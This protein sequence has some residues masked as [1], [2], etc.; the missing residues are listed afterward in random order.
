MIFEAIL[1][2][3]KSQMAYAIDETHLHIY[4]RTAKNDISKV[5]LIIGDPFEWYQK[6]GVYTWGGRSFSFKEM[7]PSYST[8]FF[9]YYFLEV[10]VP[11]KRSKYAFLIYNNND[12]YFYGCRSIEKIDLMKD[13]EFIYDLFGYFNYPYINKEDLIDSPTWTKDTV[14]YQIFLDRFNKSDNS[15]DNY[16]PFGSIKDG[17]QNNMFFGGNLL[18]VIEKIPYLKNLGISGIY[19]TP[20]FKAYTA[21]KYDT[22]DYFLI[23]PSFGTNDDFYLLV[24]ECHKAG[25]KVMLDAVFNHC[26]F[27]HPFFQD[28]IKNKRNS[29]YWDCFFIEDENFIDFALNEFGRPLLHNF[30]PKYRT[31]GFTPNMPKLNTSNP[32]MEEYLLKVAS[33]WIKEFDIDG[34]RL[35]VSNEV[36]HSFWR[37]FRTTVK[38][39]K[40]S[41]YILGENWDDSTPWLRGDQ[42]DAVMNYEI[43]YPIWQF[44]GKQKISKVIDAKTFKYQINNL[45]LRYPKNVSINMF[46]LVDSHDTMRIFTRCNNDQELVKLCYLFIFSFCGSPSI[47]YGDEIG[48]EGKDDPDSRR[49][50]IWDSS[51]QNKDLFSFF[52]RIIVLRNQYPDMKLVD[53]TWHYTEDNILIYQKNKLYFIINNNQENKTVALPFP[54]KQSAVFDVFNQVEMNLDKSI[55]LP[56][57]GFIILQ[58]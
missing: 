18:G 2:L 35:D 31:F 37:K 45:L 55:T 10:C 20:I 15:S 8:E 21:H 28:V 48:L 33:Y 22:E 51:L 41:I 50:M 47:Y 54:L 27:G 19:F 1:H 23:D 56:P 24:K 49:C 25:I 53:V 5:E 7:Q 46:N 57:Y 14:W 34:W 30:K 13:Q 44:F 52:K 17:I 39:I 4:L 36:S 38:A 26:G 58:K 43:S 3:P 12:V 11:T 40:P 6:D 42:L 16:I 29:P 9:D 32:L